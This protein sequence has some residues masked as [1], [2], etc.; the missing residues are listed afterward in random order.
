MGSAM[1]KLDILS[2]QCRAV[3]WVPGTSTD[4]QHALQYLGSPDDLVQGKGDEYKT[5]VMQR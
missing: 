1:H 5:E 3:V 4:Q 2:G